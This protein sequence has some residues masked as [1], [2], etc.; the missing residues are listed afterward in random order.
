MAV[1][2]EA[3]VSFPLS[4]PRNLCPV[5]RARRG[6]SLLTELSFDQTS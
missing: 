4:K 5:R 2:E 3:K 6:V 1:K